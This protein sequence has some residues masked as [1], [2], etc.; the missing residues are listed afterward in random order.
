MKQ[1]QGK[2]ITEEDIEKEIK[3]LDKIKEALKKEKA[4]INENST[5]TEE[6]SKA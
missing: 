5:K 6:V 4:N 2:Q 3:K 1:Q